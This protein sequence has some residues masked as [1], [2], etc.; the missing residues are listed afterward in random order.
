MDWIQG[1]TYFNI[2]FAIALW[3]V[4]TDAMINLSK[5]TRLSIIMSNLLYF[6]FDFFRLY[7]R[8]Y[9]AVE[10]RQPQELIWIW[11]FPISAI[12]NVCGSTFLLVLYLFY[13]V[14]ASFYSWYVERRR[15]I[16][17]TGVL[18]WENSGGEVAGDEG[19][20]VGEG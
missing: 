20:E 14:G 18:R 9:D 2:G 4:C 15:L 10:S 11:I 19:E 13:E 5:K 16:V 12:E 17:L 6:T 7:F 1:Y 3:L 8:V